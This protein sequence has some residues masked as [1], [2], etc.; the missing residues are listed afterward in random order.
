[1][2]CRC[3]E[4]RLAIKRAASS[5]SA[6]E[7]VAAAKFVVKTGAQDIRQLLSKVKPKQ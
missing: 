6:S 3:Q 7:A 4:R 2:V 5:K 1:M